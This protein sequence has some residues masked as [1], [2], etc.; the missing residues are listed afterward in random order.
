VVPAAL[1]FGNQSVSSASAP[2]ASTARTSIA[3]TA[4]P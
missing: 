1:Y 2:I 4:R 3:S